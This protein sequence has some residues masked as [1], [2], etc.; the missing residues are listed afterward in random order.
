M[1]R[2][3]ALRIDQ[4]LAIGDTSAM[5]NEIRHA[6]KNISDLQAQLKEKDIL[7]RTMSST[8]EIQGFIELDKA[9]EA[10]T[11]K[12]SNLAV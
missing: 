3:L 5:Q 8:R 4:A 7:M 9:K 11:R 12:P 2:T 1:F 10:V 6:T